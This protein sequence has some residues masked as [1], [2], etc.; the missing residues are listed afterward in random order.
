VGDDF[1]TIARGGPPFNQPT[2]LAVA[3]N[4]DLY[5]SDGYGNARIHVFTPD[6]EYRFSWGEPGTGPGQFNVPHALVAIA[7]DGRVVVADRENSRIQIFDP[8]GAYLGEWGGVSRPNGLAIDP[9]GTVYVAELSPNAGRY[10]FQPW[11]EPNLPPSRLSIFDLQG[12]LQARWGSEDVTAP[13]SFFAPHDVCFDSRGDLYVGET[14]L[15]ADERGQVPA[16]CHT[17]QKFVR[18]GEA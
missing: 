12:R 16:S 14:N 13:G 9:Q 8:W 15:A 2:N 17:L 18:V 7:P 3:P 10:P 11:R 1:R 5:V 6:G 4:G